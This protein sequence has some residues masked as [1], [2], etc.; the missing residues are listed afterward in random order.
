MN[1]RFVTR[2]GGT[3][4]VPSRAAYF[5]AD[6][7]LAREHANERRLAGARNHFGHVKLRVVP[8]IRNVPTNPHQYIGWLGQAVTVRVAE[9]WDAVCLWQDLLRFLRSWR[10]ARTRPEWAKVQ[11]EE[12]CAPGNDSVRRVIN[13][14]SPVSVRSS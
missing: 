11:A 13:R 3:M 12:L 6:K 8:Q 14:E 2:S 5:A 10:P 7:R 1:E 9:A 4:P